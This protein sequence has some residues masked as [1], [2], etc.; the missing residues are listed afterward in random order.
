[1]GQCRDKRGNKDKYETFMALATQE[2]LD[3]EDSP[4]QFYQRHQLL[5]LTL[6][7]IAHNLL[8]APA[9]SS[10]CESIFSHT[11]LDDSAKEV[12]SDTTKISKLAELGE[13]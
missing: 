2:R 6:S 10:Y 4:F 3:V 7:K 12:L 9:A 1:M 13:N 5:F 8:F 11:G